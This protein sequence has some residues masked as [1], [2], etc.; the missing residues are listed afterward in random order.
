METV[1]QN[2]AIYH[3][4]IAHKKTWMSLIR[5]KKSNKT[6]M[7]IWQQTK[8]LFNVLIGI[9][10]SWLLGLKIYKILNLY[11]LHAKIYIKSMI[12]AYMMIIVII[13]L[14]MKP[15]KIKSVANYLKVKIDG[16]IT[17]IDLVKNMDVMK[18]GRP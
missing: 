17:E 6:N 10:Q 8:H 18:V 12:S 14:N 9:I 4:M 13:R 11:G 7:K 2:E 15:C 5:F 16:L 3:S 1:K